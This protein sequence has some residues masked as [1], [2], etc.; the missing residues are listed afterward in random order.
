VVILVEEN[1]GYGT[2]ASLPAFASL[3]AQ[4]TLMTDSH[5]ITHPSQPNYLALWSGSTHGVT[6]NTCPTDLGDAPNLG[7]QLLAAGLTV[8]GYMESMPSDGYL[9]CS[10][11]TS[12][13]VYARKHN[14]VADF[15]ATS[16][17]A[18]DRT[19][20]SWP[21]DYSQLPTVSIVTPDLCDDMH[22]CSP[23]TGDQWLKDNLADYASWARTH[24]SLLIATFDEDDSATSAN[25][26]Y[27]VLVGEH[28]KAGSTSAQT[29][30]HYNVLHTVEAA[31][32]LPQLGA[33][34]APISG[35][36]K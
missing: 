18:T 16:G 30:N 31:Y 26:I 34:A 4:G 25:H 33:S 1:K 17:S 2:I 8:A 12:P 9:G 13:H 24:N 7:G 15:A 20:A 6:D 21:S 23:A 32:G 11:G 14:P 28:V 22:D 27:T 35:I 36:W 10:S 3:A 5:G 29:I 19:F